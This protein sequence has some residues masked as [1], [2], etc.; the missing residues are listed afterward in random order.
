M[1]SVQR[2]PTSRLI[3]EEEVEA[4]TAAPTTQTPSEAQKEWA[5]VTKALG[6][7]SSRVLAAMGHWI[8]LVIV[9]IAAALWWRVM[10]N[11]NTFQL[12]GLALYAVFGLAVIVS[13][14]G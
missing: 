4:E 13:K 11:P 12:I 7:L 1:D 9:V 2:L 8:A 3:V 10:D 14:R 5:V 6:V